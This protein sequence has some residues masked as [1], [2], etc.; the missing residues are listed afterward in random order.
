MVYFQLRQKNTSFS[1]CS[2]DPKSVCYMVDLHAP[3][4]VHD[5]LDDVEATGTF[6]A[7]SALEI[8]RRNHGHSLPFPVCHR[9]GGP[10]IAPASP[11]LDLDKDDD[12]P[13]ERHYVDL[14]AAH[15]KTASEDLHPRP[16]KVRFCFGLARPA[17]TLPWI[18]AS[19]RHALAP[20]Y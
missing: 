15:S 2:P 10:A 19:L 4:H 11:C 18:A 9:G 20:L 6:G 13:I 16:A 12:L 14:A 3:G 17:Q 5:D 8:G 7:T 1:A